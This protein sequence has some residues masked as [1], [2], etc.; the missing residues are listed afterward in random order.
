MFLDKAG[1]DACHIVKV[2]D[3]DAWR[4]TGAAIEGDIPADRVTAAEWNFTVG[5]GAGLYEK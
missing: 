4:K 3:L 1:R 2:N 5:D